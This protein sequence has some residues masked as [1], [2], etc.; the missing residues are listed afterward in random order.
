MVVIN[1]FVCM[2]DGTNKLVL[3][4]TNFSGPSRI[5]ILDELLKEGRQS[6]YSVVVYD[7]YTRTD[8]AKIVWSFVFVHEKFGWY[9]YI[10]YTLFHR[11]NCS[12]F[13]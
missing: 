4:T 10:L 9:I 1:N 7:M 3:K 2:Q 11:N 8:F 6:E 5:W 13:A 12:E